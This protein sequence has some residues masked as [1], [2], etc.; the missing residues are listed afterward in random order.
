MGN[1]L[2]AIDKTSLAMASLVI[3]GLVTLLLNALLIW[4]LGVVGA[5]IAAVVSETV[6]AGLYFIFISKHLFGVPVGG[7]MSLRSRCWQRE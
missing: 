3:N 7:G 4:Q 2:V 1:V 5:A 6:L